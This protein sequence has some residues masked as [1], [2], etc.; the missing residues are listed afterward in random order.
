MEGAEQVLQISVY[1]NEAYLQYLK[2]GF[3]VFQKHSLSVAVQAHCSVCVSTLVN[4]FLTKQI[5]NGIRS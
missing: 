2:G 3:R 1:E 4:H 5:L